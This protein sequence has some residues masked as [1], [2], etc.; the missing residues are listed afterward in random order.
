ME[1]RFQVVGEVGQRP[2]QDPD[3][4]PF[5]VV[6]LIDDYVK[7][8][9]P[10]GGRNADVVEPPFYPDGKGRAKW[11]VARRRRQN[12]QL[13]HGIAIGQPQALSF[14][15]HRSVFANYRFLLPGETCLLENTHRFGVALKTAESLADQRHVGV[16]PKPVALRH[17]GVHGYRHALQHGAGQE[18]L[19]DEDGDCLAECFVV[20]GRLAEVEP[21]VTEPVTGVFQVGQPLL[22]DKLFL[23]APLQAQRVQHEIYVA[24]LEGQHR[25]LL[26]SVDAVDGAVHEG[27]GGVFQCLVPR[28]FPVG[29]EFKHS[30]LALRVGAV[31]V[32]GHLRAGEIVVGVLGVLGKCPFFPFVEGKA[33]GAGFVFGHVPV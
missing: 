24:L 10:S 5:G 20:H 19:V 17:G 25:R 7:V 3:I 12:L 2:T 21:H 27:A 28:G 11:V 29:G 4:E 1:K 9:E 33:S 8:G 6:D 15:L 32:L 26:V 30:G 13:R 31:R 14:L 18:F 23:Q 16:V 22:A